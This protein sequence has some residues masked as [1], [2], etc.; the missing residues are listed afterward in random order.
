MSLE[1][2]IQIATEN[3]TLREIVWHSDGRI[4]AK[5]GGGAKFPKRLY[6]GKTAEEALEKLIEANLNHL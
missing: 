2:L 5:T 1:Y 6:G 3:K 4:I